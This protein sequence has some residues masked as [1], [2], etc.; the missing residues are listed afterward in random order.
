MNVKLGSV[1]SRIECSEDKV[2]KCKEDIK[3]RRGENDRPL[4]N[5]LQ[6]EMVER[7]AVQFCIELRARADNNYEHFHPL[8]WSM[9]GGPGTGKSHVIEI[10]K[11]E[12]FE[13]WLNHKT[14]D[15]F[16]IVA[17]Q[18]VMGICWKQISS[19]ML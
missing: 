3:D 5:A 2:R 12:R 13:K 14:T 11:T 17:L 18:A 19:T 6:Y 4:L 1:G 16:Q 8:R 15:D 7:V 10:I 9:H